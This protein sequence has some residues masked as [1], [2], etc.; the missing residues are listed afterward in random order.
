MLQDSWLTFH[1]AAIITP[2]LYNLLNM[3]AC[4]C[5]WLID[6]WLIDCCNSAA[7]SVTKS[8]PFLCE[9]S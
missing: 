5:S 3:N 6:C 9:L 7:K 1:T 8:Q 2:H 4:E